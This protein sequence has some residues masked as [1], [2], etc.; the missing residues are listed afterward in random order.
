[1]D[2]VH[3]K[4]LRKAKRILCLLPKRLGDALFNTPAF[5][6][7]QQQLPEAKIDALCLS[8]IAQEMLR[9]NRIFSQVHLATNEEQEREIASNYDI[10]VA[11]HPADFA[12][13]PITRLGIPAIQ[14][15]SRPL[16]VTPA[17]HYLQFVQSLVGG[18]ADAD[19]SCYDLLPCD[20]ERE[21]VRRILLEKG[22]KPG[23]HTLIGIHLGAHGVAK[24][25]LLKFWRSGVHWKVWPF[26]K[27]VA[28]ARELAKENSNIRFILTGTKFE[29][30]LGK[31]FAAKVKPCINLIGELSIL[32]LA[33]LMREL[34][35]YIASDTGPLHVACSA[36]INV[37]GLYS[38]FGVETGTT[39]YPAKAQHQLIQ[40][41]NVHDIPVKKVV[42]MA[43]KMLGMEMSTMG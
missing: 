11:L 25:S 42:R 37:L 23:E 17:E 43:A 33:A 18:E 30:T 27:F 39:P 13:S 10:V 2:N 40:S 35:L 31:K 5:K 3:A 7:L 32:E 6:L 20:E 36:E 26:K 21:K 9:N 24:R 15:P 38:D 29:K 16:G 41:T 1:M 34:D 22:V 4:T 28:M 8:T 14:C 12:Q 19:I